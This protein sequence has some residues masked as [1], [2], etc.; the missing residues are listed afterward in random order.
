LLLLTVYCWR[1]EHC[2]VLLLL[3]LLLLKAQKAT[4]RYHVE[5][6]Q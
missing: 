2:Q 5:T 6:P 4:K 1:L 3:L